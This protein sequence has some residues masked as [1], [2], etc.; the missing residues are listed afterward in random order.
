MIKIDKLDKAMDRMSDKALIRLIK[1]CICRSVFGAG[2]SDT[3]EHLALD[4]AYVE[5]RRRG[6]ERLYDSAYASVSSHPERC[7]IF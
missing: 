3:G 4:M 2:A 1:R 7:D 6:K 5:C